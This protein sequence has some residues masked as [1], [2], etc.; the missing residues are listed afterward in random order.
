MGRGQAGSWPT[1]TEEGFS[2]HLSPS[3]KGMKFFFTLLGR[4]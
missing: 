3:E 2:L 4:E 1:D